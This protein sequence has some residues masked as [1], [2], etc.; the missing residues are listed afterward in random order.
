MVEISTRTGSLE[1]FLIGE[2][3]SRGGRLDRVNFG[4]GSIWVNL[5]NPNSFKLSTHLG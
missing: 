1:I 5:C 4:F 3:M 2:G